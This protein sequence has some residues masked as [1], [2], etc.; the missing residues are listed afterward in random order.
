VTTVA[1]LLAVGA[2]S[3]LMRLTPWIVLGRVE[4]SPRVQSGLAYAGVGAV[5]ALLTGNV[6]HAG[7]RGTSIAGLL[8]GLV[9][10]GLLLWRGRSTAVAIGAGFVMYLVVAAVS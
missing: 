2:V 5:T 6:L 3:Y 7:E 8:A 1:A 9:V 10:T 4:L